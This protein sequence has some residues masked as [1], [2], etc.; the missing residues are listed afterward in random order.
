M[1]KNS[2][3]CCSVFV[4]PPSCTFLVNVSLPAKTFSILSILL[5]RFFFYVTMISLRA[6]APLMV[7][8]SSSLILML[9]LSS[10]KLS[11]LAKGALFS[12]RGASI[13]LEFFFAIH[14]LV[15][16]LSQKWRRCG[17]KIFLLS[18]QN[19]LFGSHCGQIEDWFLRFLHRI[20]N[21]YEQLCFFF[22]LVVFFTCLCILIF[23]QALF[24]S[25]LR[26][27]YPDNQL[28]ALNIHPQVQ[29]IKWH[30]TSF[31]RKKVHTR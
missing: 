3:L 26:K 22:S 20:V 23:I 9:S 16:F 15:C 17:W 19:A 2:F 29:K 8:S 11:P 5:R 13:S 10:W 31:S 7:I 12:S 4:D 6:T 1:T 14:Q 30:H 25:W 21:W 24:D 27:S 18:V 28:H